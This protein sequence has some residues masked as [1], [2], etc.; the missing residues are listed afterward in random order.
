MIPVRSEILPAIQQTENAISG[1]NQGDPNDVALHNQEDL[2][3]QAHPTQQFHPQSNPELGQAVPR[4]SQ[5]RGPTAVYHHSADTGC[6]TGC[7]NSRPPRDQ[8]GAHGEVVQVNLAFSSQGCIGPS[9]PFCTY[10]MENIPYQLYNA[11]VTDS[12]WLKRVQ[13][14]QKVNNIRGEFCSPCCCMTLFTMIFVPCTC[15]FFCKQN[16]TEIRVWNDAL[17]KWQNDFNDE[18]LLRQGC[19]IKTRSDCKVYYTDSGKSRIISR[20][21]AIALTPEQCAILRNESHLTGDISEGCCGGINE[22][23]CCIHPEL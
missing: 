2:Q 19:F 1:H 17:L 21:I 9:S 15:S 13:M 14:L 20:W 22:N 16:A 6:W 18:V 12:E 23:E 10:D 4:P 8:R 11:G 7:C 3:L 5:L